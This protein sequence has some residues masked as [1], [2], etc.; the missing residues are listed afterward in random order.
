MKVLDKKLFR[1]IW[2]QRGQALA[3]AAVVLCGTASYI[4]VASAHRNLL[5]TRDTYYSQ[6]RFADFEIHLERAPLTSA[7]KLE[8]IPGVRQVRARIVKEV[9]LDIEGQDEP[10]IGR[11]VS[12]PDTQEPVLNDVCLVAGRYFDQGVQNQVILNERFAKMNG[13]EIGGDIEVSVGNKKHALRIVGFGLSPEYVYMI[14]NVQELVPSPERFGI[15]WVP[16]D[17]AE[18]ALAMEAACNNI[19]GSVEKVDDLDPILDAAEKI[20]EPYGVF[21]KT[22]RENQISNRFLCDEIRG[23]GISAKVI[24]GIFLGIASMILLILLNRM[25]RKERTEIGLLK[26]YGYTNAAV[27]WHYL[28]FA[29]ILALAGCIGAFFVGQ[30]LAREIIKLYVQFYEFPLLRARVYPDVLARSMSMAGL[31][32]LG[33][34]L[35][36][37]WQAAQIDPAQSMRAEAPKHAHRI[38]LE[39]FTA[40]WTRLS[41]TWKM[42]AR[43]VSR[44][45]FR[46]ALNV[47]GVAIS[48]GLIITGYF[49]IDAI[50]FMLKY[51]FH[52]V[53]REDVKVSFPIER[54][55]DAFYSVRRFDHVR[56]A[57]PVLQYPFEVSSKWRKKDTIIIGLP[58]DAHLQKLLDEDKRYVDV[59]DQGLVLS[60]RLAE[61]LHVHV[62][63]SVTLKP[64][65]GRITDERDVPVRQVVKQYLGTSGYM[66]IHAL[67]R[68]LDQGFAMNAA[69]LQVEPG[70]ER[71]L[72][73]SLKDVPGISSVEIKD[74][75]YVNLLNT[76]GRNIK[77][78]NTILIIFAG[79]I[80][81][82]VIYNVTT[83]ALAERQRELASLRVL[84]FTIEEVGRIVYHENFVLAGFGVVFGIPVGMGIASILV[85]LYDNELYRLPYYIA[86]KTYVIASVATIVFVILANLAV[87]HKIRALDMVEVLKARE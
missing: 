51:Q 31:A 85:R 8:A 34:A 84:G 27:S 46:A 53:R 7:F 57:E 19:I 14:R 23:L 18:T 33:G 70:M 22:K 38:W 17:F 3:V 72:N 75:S 55:K 87:K 64:L 65:M 26:A 11:I 83:I 82:S 63:D 78:I 49:T 62:G 73:A 24:P 54:G 4:C 20:L 10:R 69:L 41:F 36:A 13:L 81:C 25:V 30:W 43:N 80:A 56:R 48:S 59:G 40:L 45:S 16:H 28:K 6:Y 60:K 58:R 71:S 1:G 37:A 29:I 2:R 79:V 77:I 15:L 66:N 67:S 76:L 5:L 47:F 12:M 52:E 21:A 74:M 86:P 39:H 9:N 61:E 42:I 35:M 32:A 68:V 44:S 50:N